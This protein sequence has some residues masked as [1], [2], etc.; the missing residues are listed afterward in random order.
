LAS[1]YEVKEIY[2]FLSRGAFYFRALPAFGLLNFFP[3]FAPPKA[4]AGFIAR[5]HK[6]LKFKYRKKDEYFTGKDR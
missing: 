1:G 4:G 6:V 5:L 2:W 3:T